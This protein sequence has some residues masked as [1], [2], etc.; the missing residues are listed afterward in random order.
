M[1][2]KNAAGD[3]LGEVTSGTF[4]PTLKSG[5]ALALVDSKIEINDKVFVDVRGNS[6]EFVVT[7][8][9]FVESKVR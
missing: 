8:P 9:P 1:Q 5:I 6:L 2:V 3:V 4:S 7:K